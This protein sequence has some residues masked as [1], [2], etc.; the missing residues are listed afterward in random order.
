MLEKILR[1]QFAR[2][3]SGLAVSLLAGLS[4]GCVF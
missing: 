2:H 4:L 3:D 1:G